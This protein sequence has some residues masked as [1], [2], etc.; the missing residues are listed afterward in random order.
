MSEL[1]HAVTGNVH[2]A[3]AHEGDEFDLSGLGADAHDHHG[4]CARADLRIIFPR[5]HAEQ[6][7]VDHTV[8]YFECGW[9][10]FIVGITGHQSDG[11]QDEQQKENKETDLE[12]LPKRHFPSLLFSL[13][14]N[15]ILGIRNLFAVQPHFAPPHARL[16]IVRYIVIGLW[17]VSF[18][19]IAP[20]WG[21]R[22]LIFFIILTLRGGFNRKIRN[23][24]KKM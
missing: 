9:I 24:S 22:L 19:H 1:G 14:R 12:F 2:I 15:L 20:F 18:H 11:V 17:S 4:V 13:Y 16:V 10:F 5:V 21:Q 3:V 6:R 7:N 23:D 8:L